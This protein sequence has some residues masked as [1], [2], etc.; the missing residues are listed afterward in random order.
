MQ[1]LVCGIG[2]LAVGLFVS[3]GLGH[4]VAKYFRAWLYKSAGVAEPDSKAVP[5]WLVGIVERTLFTLIVAAV[6]LYAPARLLDVVVPAFVWIG[7]KMATHWQPPMSGAT[8]AEKAAGIPSTRAMAAILTGLLSIVMA[9]VGGLI[10]AALV[11]CGN[12]ALGC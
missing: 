10:T 12:G 11:R 2:S 6:A 4:L 5:N 3:V 1:L 7:L 9:A 8:E